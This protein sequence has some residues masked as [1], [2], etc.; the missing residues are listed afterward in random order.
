MTGARWGEVKAVLA[1]VLEAPP[2]KRAALIDTLCGSDGEM[3]AS[4]ESMLA[5]EARAEELL[6]T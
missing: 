6:N 4:V 3:R 2:E 5:M 1:A